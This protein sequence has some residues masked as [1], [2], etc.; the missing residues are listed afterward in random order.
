MV[1]SADSPHLRRMLLQRSHRW[2]CRHGTHASVDRSREVMFAREHYLLPIKSEC[3]YFTLLSSNTSDRTLLL[4]YFCFRGY[5]FYSFIIKKSAF[6]KPDFYN[7]VAMRWRGG[8][9]V[10]KCC[11]TLFPENLAKLHNFSACAS[12]LAHTL[13][14]PGMAQLLL[15]ERSKM[16]QRFDTGYSN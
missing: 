8:V 6:L 16:I 15:H 11:S 4:E 1:C 14:C 3:K 9:V 13:P 5:Y 2:H 12:N 7:D 10:G